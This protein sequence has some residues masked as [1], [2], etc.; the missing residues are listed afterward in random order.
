[1]VIGPKLK[2]Y[3]TVLGIFVLGA[4]AGGASGY[5]VANKRL[6]AVLSEDRPGMGDARRMEA[7]SDEL[8]LT[9]EQRRQVRQIME[10]HRDENR[11]L[12][13]AMLEKCGGELQEL[14]SRVD[15]EIRAVLTEQQAKR[16]KELM[17]KRGKRFPLGGPGPRRR[18]GD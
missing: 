2:L 18:K 17:E 13:R 1:M 12:Q 10:R 15:G 5:A 7:L 11:D 9:R 16:F 4:G 3:G 6:A 14:R 8:D